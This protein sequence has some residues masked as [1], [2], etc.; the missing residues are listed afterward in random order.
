MTIKL[1]HS[2]QACLLVLVVASFGLI[3]CAS[4]A[5]QTTPDPATP[6]VIEVPAEPPPPPVEITENPLLV[7]TFTLN[8]L[9]EQEAG[10]CGMS[11]MIPNADP[12]DGFLFTHGIDDAPA[13][14]KI[15]G[16]WVNLQR[17]A[18]S[19]EEFYG[20]QTSQTF[21]SDDGATTVDVNVSLGEPGEIESVSLTDAV[22]TVTRGEQV[23]ELDVMGD[24][25]C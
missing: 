19:G 17:T 4:Q 24:A 14:M 7:D 25:G 13:L 1:K 2:Y 8:E 6:S 20:Q 22:L 11:L 23:L 10:G 12:G 16:E 21:V 3:G 5:P 9:F 15:N 18:A